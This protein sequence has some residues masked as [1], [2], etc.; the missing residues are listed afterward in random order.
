MKKLS[1]FLFV[2]LLFA[3]C[4][5][6]G[7]EFNKAPVD[8]LIRD[9]SNEPVFSIILHDMDV[10]G[11]FAKVYK[12]QYRI[13]TNKDSLPVESVTEWMEVSKDYFW[14]N[15]DNMGMEIASKTEDGKINKVASPPGYNNYVGN[16][17]YGYWHNSNG[18]SFWTFYGQYAFMSHMLSMTN[19]PVYQRDYRDYRGG[20]YGSKPYYGGSSTAPKYGTNSAHN[21]KANPNFFERRASKSGWSSSK[22]RTSRTGRNSSRSGSSSTM[23]S[24][25][26]SY[27]K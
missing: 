19:R 7:K 27:G 16:Q 4:G 21:R 22:H 13:I 25:G 8:D 23:R 6:G 9:M 5:G 14:K 15:E 1:I 11:T 2:G 10:D 3:A 26:G 20:Y 18:N 12:H 24:R 17:R